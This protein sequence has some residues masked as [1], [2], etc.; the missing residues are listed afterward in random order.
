MF[1]YLFKQFHYCAPPFLR[2]KRGLWN[3]LCPSIRP[4]VHPPIHS[5][6]CP[7][8]HPFVHPFH[9]CH[10]SIHLSICP[11]VHPF[12]HPFHTWQMRQL[13]NH[14]PNSFLIPFIPTVLSYT[15]ATSWSVA[16]WG[17]LGMPTNQNS[18][19]TGLI[20]SKSSSLETSRPVYVQC[21]SDM[22]LMGMSMGVIR[23]PELWTLELSN[24]W[25]DSLQI[26]FIGTVL[27][28]TC[29]ISW[30]FAHWGL[31]CMYMGVIRAPGTL[32]M[33]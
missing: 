22:G 2:E 14:W 5:S 28:C 12:V 33:P 1:T 13:S 16:H 8:V 24:H 27:S 21:H 23:A 17:L 31:M 32:W 15:C 10:P 26:K 3:C 9:T 7:S 4:S 6:I 29:L 25:A 30:P 19:T 11:S 20:H 18:A